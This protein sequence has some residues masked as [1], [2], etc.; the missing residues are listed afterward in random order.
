MRKP[1]QRIFLL[2]A[3]LLGLEPAECVF[4]DDI[5]ENVAAAQAAGLVGVLHRTAGETAEQLSELLG[6]SL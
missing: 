4:I 1:E 6:I 3:E 2:A 5:A